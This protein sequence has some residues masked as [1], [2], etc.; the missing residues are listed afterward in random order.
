MTVITAKSSKDEV[1]TAACEI[2]DSQE[3][4]IKNLTGEKNT[5]IFLV[6]VLSIICCLF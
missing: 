5:L 6:S 2:V 1:I 4:V 3:A